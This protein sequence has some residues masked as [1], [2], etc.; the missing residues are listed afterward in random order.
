MVKQLGDSRH[1]SLV[2]SVF[3][4]V[5]RL[6]TPIIRSL[7]CHENPGRNSLGWLKAGAFPLLEVLNVFETTRSGFSADCFFRDTFKNWNPPFFIGK[8]HGFRCSDLA[9][10]KTINKPPKTSG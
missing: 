8:T 2:G 7:R 3:R 4:E 9:Q 6:L 10:A 5:H 1:A